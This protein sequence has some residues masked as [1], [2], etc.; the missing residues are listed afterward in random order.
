MQGKY[1][2][3]LTD[4]FALEHKIAIFERMMHHAAHIIER[5]GKIIMKVL[6]WGV[7]SFLVVNT[8]I[9]FYYNSEIYSDIDDL[10][11]GSDAVMILGAS[12]KG[13]KL[14][15]ILQDRAETA[16]QVYQAK[17]AAKI[18]ISGDG[19]PEDFYDEVATIKKYLIN[20]GIP[21][22]IV[23]VDNG[24]FDTYDS[25]WRA[26]HIFG[27]THITISTQRFH[28]P[29]ALLIAHGL[30]IQ[31]EWIAADRTVYTNAERNALR[32]SFARIKAVWDI[33]F[34]NQPAINTGDRIDIHGN[35]NAYTDDN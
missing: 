7:F 25:L 27:I 17:K 10:P 13:N 35:G 18:L 24:G 9:F 22:H 8:I 5:I 16:I 6:L 20:R 28:L 19:D 2:L 33:I 23:F 32:E 14:S 30:G 4:I 21:P 11:T 26:K 29:R 31:A 3:L 1:G 12:V 15:Q 34:K